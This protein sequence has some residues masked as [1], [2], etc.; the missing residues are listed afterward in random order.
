M[1]AV[2]IDHSHR[3]GEPEHRRTYNKTRVFSRL[4]DHSARGRTPKLSMKEKALRLFG[5]KLYRSRLRKP[6]QRWGAAGTISAGAVEL[7][8]LLLKLEARYGHVDPSVAWL[9][10]PERLNVPEKVVHAWKAQLQEHGFLDWERRCVETGNAGRRGPQLHQTSNRYWTRLPRKALEL[11]SL[12]RSKMG[13]K[14]DPREVREEEKAVMSPHARRR[15]EALEARLK[16]EQFAL[17]RSLSGLSD[18]MTQDEAENGPRPQ[19]RT[20]IP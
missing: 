14:A 1:T 19:R 16:A 2:P 13:L 17:R 9:A 11:V 10:D 15:N 8:E 6:G 5:L 7:Y 20:R 18:A 3:L 12:V 4:V